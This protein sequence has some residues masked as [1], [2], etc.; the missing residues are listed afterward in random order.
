MH[1]WLVSLSSFSLW[2]TWACW[3]HVAEE[4]KFKVDLDDDCLLL[5]G[6]GGSCCPGG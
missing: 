2:F 6:P 1:D 3:V 4:K 5:L